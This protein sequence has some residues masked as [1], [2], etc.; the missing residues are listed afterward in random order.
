[1][2]FFLCWATDLC[3]FFIIFFSK[4]KDFSNKTNKKHLTQRIDIYLLVEDN[5]K[6]SKLWLNA[7]IEKNI[8]QPEV[9]QDLD[10][11]IK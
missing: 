2:S 3:D 5:F 1:M 9:D 11:G 4:K 8:I 10:Q 6:G 7:I